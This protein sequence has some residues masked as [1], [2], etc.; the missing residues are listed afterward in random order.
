MVLD[1]EWVEELAAE[2]VD[3]L[4]SLL[5]EECIQIEL[6]MASKPLLVVQVS[7]EHMHLSILCC[8]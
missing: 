3:E 5:A 8:L 6:E 1:L 4:A 2:W 7:E